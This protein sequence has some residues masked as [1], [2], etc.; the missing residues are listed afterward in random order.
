MEVKMDYGKLLNLPETDFPMRGNLPQK[1]PGIQQWWE[2]IDIYREVQKNRNGHTKFVLHDG[3]PY[4]NG[5][6]HVG[7]ALNKIIKDIIVKYK[8]LRGFDSPYV[9]GWDTH[10]LPIE[11]AIIKNEKLDRHQISVIDFRQKCHDYA[12]NYIEKQRVQFKRL[13]I[14]G[15]WDNPYITL[16]PDYE[17]E[18]IKV[19]GDMANKGHIYKGKKPVYWC[20]SC[21][22]ALAEAEIEYHDKSSD[23]IY[24]SF[25]VKDGKGILSNDSYVVIWTT[26]P[27]TIPANMAISLHPNFEYTLIK[28]N[29]KKYLVAKELVEDL[30]KTFKLDD[31]SLEGSW[32][33]RELEGII[34]KHPLYDRESP[35]ILGE[36]VT[37]EQGTGCVHTAPGH[38][39]DDYLVALKYDLDIFAPIDNKGHFTDE[40]EDLAG[41]FYAKANKLVVAS[42]QE[43]GSSLSAETIKHQ[44]PHCWRCKQSVIYRATEQWFASIDGFR[45]NMLDEIKNVEWIPSWGEQRMYNMIAD[46]GDWCISRQRVW[47]VPIPILYCEKCNKEVI[48]EDSINKISEIFEVEGS[49]AWWIR[50]ASDFLATGYKCDCGHDTFRKESDIMDVWFDSGSSHA[51][52]ARKRPELSW[53]TDMYLEG[54]DQYRGWFNSSLST[55]VATTGQAPYRSVL[56]CGMVVDGQGRKMSKSLGNGVDPIEVIEKL[57][58]DILRLWVSSAEYTADIRISDNILQQMA[59]IYRKI[60][61]TFRFLLGNL[62]DFNPDKDKIAYDDLYE[63]DKYALIKLQELIKRTGEAYDKYD[64]HIVF[65]AT[66]NFC[67]VDMSAFYL[68]ILKDR[69]YTSAPNSKSRRAAQT[70]LHQIL[71][72]LITILTPILSHTVEEIWSYVPDKKYISPQ[73][74]SWP[75]LDVKYMN[76]GIKNKWDKI[77]KIREEILK[78]LEN[79]RKEKIIGHSLGAK[80]EIYPDIDV[81]NVLKD[82]EDLDK[83]LIVS[84][85]ILHSVGEPVPSDAEAVK[86]MS[87][88]VSVADGEKCERCWVIATSVGEDSNHPTLCKSCAGTIKDFL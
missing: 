10:G 56:S 30:V 68:D 59:E 51:A 62:S 54:S 39:M 38:G 25:Q 82:I 19:F 80:V 66:H 46:R 41:A 29:D 44:Y 32:Q 74:N 37:L 60:R 57:G 3:P 12:M 21:E 4:A 77:V 36:H 14:R 87:I 78:P 42:L 88:V 81:Y 63:I 84:N 24:V 15:D 65:H 49:Q 75:E 52:V 45:Q 40:V 58:A 35:I 67:T 69:L 43:K 61:N 34:T 9:P 64:F 83:I 16:K 28:A 79:A 13:G 8:T 53:P 27:W 55:S 86:G 20:A 31:Y 23:S 48:N 85:V 70:T 71:H 76:E 50:P 18:Q 26:T 17:A 7:H 2:E 11:Y 1:E 6:I 33:G 72:D 47:G 73:M 5:D 22:T